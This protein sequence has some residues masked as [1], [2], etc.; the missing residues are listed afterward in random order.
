MSF[1]S[2][3]TVYSHIWLTTVIAFWA[4]LVPRPFPLP[5]FDYLQY[6]NT[7]QVRQGKVREILLHCTWARPMGVVP[8]EESHCPFLCCLS[9]S[10]LSEHLHGRRPLLF[11]IRIT[12]DRL[13]W[14]RYYDPPCVYLMSS[15]MTK[16]PRPSPAIFASCK[17]S[18]DV[19]GSGLGTRLILTQG[20]MHLISE[21]ILC[22]GYLYVQA[23]RQ[24]KQCN[25]CGSRECASRSIVDLQAIITT[26]LWWESHSPV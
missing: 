21:G 1:A 5:V 6:A 24:N 16:S 8:T 15:H 2:A 4:S 20:C 12:K 25:L 22:M 26:P 23:Y 3:V 19:C 11:T 13:T 17:R 7:V 14:N 18:N 9:K 10:W